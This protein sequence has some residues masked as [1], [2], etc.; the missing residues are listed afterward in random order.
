MKCHHCGA[1]S[2]ETS[3]LP[4]D[5]SDNEL[6]VV[7]YIQDYMED[8]GFSPTIREICSETGIRSTST[9]HQLLT[10]LKDRGL[11]TNDRR[12]GRTLRFV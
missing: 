5:L 7:Y 3:V 8:N 9:V 2:K 6:K 10:Q 1:V 12:S 4:D 11:I